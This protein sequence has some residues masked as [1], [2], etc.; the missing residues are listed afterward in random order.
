MK[1][2]VKKT[3]KKTRSRDAMV[4]DVLAKVRRMCH[5]AVENLCVQDAEFEELEWMLYRYV[6]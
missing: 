5:Y 1:K 6:K 3:V 4:E 2:I